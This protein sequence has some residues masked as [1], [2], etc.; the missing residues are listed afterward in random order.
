MRKYI[1]MEAF[2]T[3]EPDLQTDERT[4]RKR[5]K[6]KDSQYGEPSSG[7]GG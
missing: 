7:A 2:L 4:A 3:G 1:I 6:D 5:L